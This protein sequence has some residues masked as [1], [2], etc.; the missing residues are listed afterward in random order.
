MPIRYRCSPTGSLAVDGHPFGRDAEL[1]DVLAHGVVS[2]PGIGV[3]D[4]RASVKR[5]SMSIPYNAQRF[6]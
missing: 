1:V 4:R 6:E 5:H 3:N 2:M